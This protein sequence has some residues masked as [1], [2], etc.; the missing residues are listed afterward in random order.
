MATDMND[1]REPFIKQGHGFQNWLHSYKM[2]VPF[3]ELSR[4]Q[5]WLRLPSFS[6][7]FG[8][9]SLFFAVCN[10]YVAKKHSIN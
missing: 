9:G 5:F 3:P 8:K 1:L 10:K 6:A 4:A 2:E 7:T